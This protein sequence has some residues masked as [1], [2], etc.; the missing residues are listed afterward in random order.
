MKHLRS[1]FIFLFITSITIYAGGTAS[2]VAKKSSTKGYTYSKSTRSTFIQECSE[3]ANQDICYCVLDIIQQ[4]YS[5][6]QY[7]KFDADLRKNIKHNDFISFISF[8]AEICDAEYTVNNIDEQALKDYLNENQSSKLTEEEANE[9][10][11]IFLKDVSKKNFVSNCAPAAK[12]FYGEKTA[13]QVCGCA[14]DHIVSDVPR[15]TQFI[16]NNGY[17]DGTD[18]STWGKEYMYECAPE[19]F[20]PE[21]KKNL[22]NL[23]NQKGVPQSVGTCFVKVIE[24]E[25][26][27]Q[28]FITAAKDYFEKDPVFMKYL[29][30]RISTCLIEMEIDSY[31][32]E[33][34]N[35][36]FNNGYAE[37]GS[38]GI[39]DGLAGLLGGGGGGI[40]TKAKGSIKT[41]STRDVIISHNDGNRGEN[42]IMKVV[43]QRTPGLRHIYNKS[44]KKKPGF[45]GKVTLKF[46][47]APGGEII[48][49]SIVSSTTGFSEFDREIK[50]AVGRWK[51]NKIQS[52]NT[53]VSIP[54]TFS[55]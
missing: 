1:I 18:T 7:L 53:T 35:N 6:K 31:S 33:P 12:D 40:A 30:E 54:F 47:I 14:Y 4:Q 28:A 25:Y 23:M 48:S 8:A 17:P 16:M 20:T 5:E 9:Y 49:I 11:N 15:F 3:N 34:I 32:N 10:V 44:L 26:S 45:Q 55:E 46:T 13:S 39:G 42:D 19:K 51:F 21:M 22:I 29:N 38:E 43:R 37:G 27:V 50:D 52:G 2:L 24:K 41:P 36:N